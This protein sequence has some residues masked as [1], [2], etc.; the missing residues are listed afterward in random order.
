MDYDIRSEVPI[1]LDFPPTESYIEL[2]LSLGAPAPGAMN[3]TN[4]PKKKPLT[5][6]LLRVP[7][8][9]VA[10]RITLRNAMA[11]GAPSVRAGLANAREARAFPGANPRSQTAG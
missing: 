11:G 6:L 3:R 7:P 10:K 9:A 4:R 8:N 5:S 2:E 1:F